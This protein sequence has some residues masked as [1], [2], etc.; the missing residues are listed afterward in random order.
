MD[1]L[2]FTLSVWAAL[3]IGVFFIA[4]VIGCTL[5]RHNSNEGFKWFVFVIGLIGVAA[6]HWGE[7]SWSQLFSAEVWKPV[8]IYLA[9]GLAYSVLEFFVKVRK[10]AKLWKAEWEKFKAKDE[11]PDEDHNPNELIIKK[12]YSHSLEFRFCKD[13][14]Y[15]SLSRITDV[16]CITT[17]GKDAVVPV[18]NRSELAQS[19]GCWTLFWPAYAFSLILGDLLT[20]VFKK[21]ADV[22]V[23][24]SSGLVRRM[25]AK[26]FTP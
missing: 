26:V 13:H 8:L 11:L 7:W 9:I 19:V 1:F 6:W 3:A 18:I 14:H 24:L 23:A 12:S 2:G 17:D 4:M 15:R 22:I 21:F 5:D 10:E 20:E 16:K 25:F